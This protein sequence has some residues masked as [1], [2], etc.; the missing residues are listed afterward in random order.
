MKEETG[1]Q[2]FPELLHLCVQATQNYHGKLQFHLQGKHRPTSAYLHSTFPLGSLIFLRT[3]L[4]L[5]S[6]GAGRGQL[7]MVI[8]STLL[9]KT[10][11]SFLL[12][13]YQKSDSNNV[14]EEALPEGQT[15]H[16]RD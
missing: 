15:Y 4:P 9:Q 5:Y 10:T 1:E 14:P 12:N 3:L 6:A 13:S 7:F 11:S 16:A 2:P 8:V